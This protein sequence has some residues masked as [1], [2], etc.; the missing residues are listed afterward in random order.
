MKKKLTAFSWGYW[1][2]GTKAERFIEAAAAHEA[3]AGFEPPAFA[4]VRLRR[5][6]RAEH[7]KDNHFAK[8]VGQDRYKWFPGLGNAHIA[9]HKRG[10]RIAKPDEAEDLLEYIKAQAKLKRR[11]MFFC[12]CEWIMTDGKPSC[13]RHAVADLLLA[14]ARKQG[15]NLEIVEWP[16]DEPIEVDIDCDDEIR[17][18]LKNTAVSLGPVLPEDGLATLPWGSVVN[19]VC[20]EDRTPTPIVTGPAI[21]KKGHWRLPI[22]LEL[23]EDNDLDTVAEQVWALREDHGFEPRKSKK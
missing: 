5:S 9:T 23:P 16:G 19:F 22:I 18:T 4:D 21:F 2:W 8:I 7:F 11:V 20:E 10:M 13:H 1:G 15:I 14:A 17:K 6:V 12:A 3:A